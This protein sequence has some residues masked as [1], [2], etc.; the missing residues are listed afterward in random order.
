MVEVEEVEAVP[1]LV[2]LARLARLVLRAPQGVLRVLPLALADLEAVEVQVV[3]AIQGQRGMYE[4]RIYRLYTNPRTARHRPLDPRTVAADIMEVDPRQ[5]TE[6]AGA[7][8]PV[9]SLLH[10]LEQ[11]SASS[12]G[13]GFTV[14]TSTTTIIRTTT[15]IAPTTRTRVY[16][17]LACV[18]STAPAVAMTITTPL[19]STQW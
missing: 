4:R 11:Q 16:R 17:L 13:Y 15:T 2:L 9:Y 12:R 1:R 8:Q 7:P 19:S 6:P 3:L 10:S 14:H 18:T 5:L